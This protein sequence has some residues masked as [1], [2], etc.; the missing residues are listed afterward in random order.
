MSE[1][2]SRMHIAI[3]ARVKARFD[4]FCLR[5]GVTMSE[6][7]RDMI[8]DLIDGQSATEDEIRAYKRTGKFKG[9]FK[10]KAAR[11]AANGANHET[12]SR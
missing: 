12:D 9:I 3:P 7:A 2:L 4:K 1:K 11:A 5:H 8:L 10:S 6:M